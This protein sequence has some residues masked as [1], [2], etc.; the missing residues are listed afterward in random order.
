M[1]SGRGPEQARLDALLEEARQG[2]SATL[3]VRGEPG[4]GK[5][6]LL[7]YAVA[8]AQDMTVLSAIGVEAESE[9]AYAALSDLLQP[10]TSFLSDIPEPQAAAL[11]GALA[12][13]PPH[14]EDAFAVSAG[15]SGLLAAAAE[16]RPVLAVIDDAH[17]LDAASLDALRFAA[18]RL[19]SDRTVL[20]FGMRESDPSLLGGI[21]NLTLRGLDVDAAHEI[22]TSAA[23]RQVPRPVSEHLCAATGGNPLA[24]LEIIPRL[25]SAQLSGTEGLPEV[26]PTG[27]AIQ[28]SFE[29]RVSTMQSQT[30][31]AML[32]V[33][34]SQSGLIRELQ[35]ACQALGVSL[36]ALD[37]A[38][39]S[40][41]I[42]NDGL[43]IQ[44]RHPLIRSA[45]Y[46]A[47]AGPARRAVHRALAE[48]ATARG[49]NLERAWHLATAVQGH[50]ETVAVALEDAA[51]DARRRTGYAAAANAIERAARLSLDDNQRARRLH[52]AGSDAYVGGHSDRSIKLLEEAASL[53]EEADLRGDIALTRGRIEMWTGSPAAARRILLAAADQLEARDPAKAALMLVDAASTCFQEADP[54]EGMIRPAY[55][56]SKRAYDAARCVGGTPEAAAGGML[57]VILI[58][59]GQARDGYP[60]LERSVAA[61]QNADSMWLQIQ[62]IQC[63]GIFIYLGEYDRVRPPLERLIESAR[64]QGAFS[65][66][67]Y[68]LGHLSDLDYRLGRWN[69]AAAEAAEAIDLCVELGHRFSLIYALASLARVDAARGAEAECR[70]HLDRAV[71]VSGQAV[72]GVGAHVVRILA[73]LELGLGRYHEAVKRLERL[74]SAINHEAAGDEGLYPEPGV[75]QYQPD[76]IEGYVSLG[77]PAEALA[78]LEKFEREAQDSQRIWALATAAR[79]RGLLQKDFEPHFE[80][81]LRWHDRTPTPFERARTELCF[82]ERLRRARRRGDARDRLRTALE[83]FEVLGATPWAERA[84][85][86]L[87]ATGETAR[88]DYSPASAEL[89]LQ[90]LQ[91]AMKVAEGATNKEVAAALFLSPKT[92]E[93]HLGRIYSKLGLRSR[94][95]LSRRLSQDSTGSSLRPVPAASS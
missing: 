35:P 87:R 39:E 66:L 53:T 45:V 82:G 84:R 95:E 83:T 38:E 16:Q 44:F 13:G 25:S 4:I 37:P 69:A 85:N 31:T 40:G 5:T 1:L 30:R 78:V 20:L 10:I 86:E 19:A 34:A 22:L 8:R 68:A 51:A 90:E 80:E 62:L 93:A 2:R 77:R 28:Q 54:L 17:W 81:A 9:L 55:Q 75:F 52:Q 46:H 58:F 7:K 42:E 71:Q 64:S 15:S 14:A 27:P 24:M 76:L 73:L 88:R 72:T 91:V 56:I 43:R 67:P 21:P 18:R 47:S 49:A 48:A 70:A 89:T 61:I 74:E 59:R 12:L 3:V 57:G 23:K 6:A 94:T 65:V 63:T 26:L 92:V 32:V 79:C 33:A 41:L 36:S 50:D 29:Q 60:L 11:A